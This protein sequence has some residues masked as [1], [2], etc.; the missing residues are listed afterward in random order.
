MDQ[1]GVAE[2]LIAVCC[3][4]AIVALFVVGVGAHEVARHL[5]QGAPLWFGLIFGMRGSG[6][7]KW[8]GLAICLFWLAIAVLIGLHVTGQARIVTGD[9]TP[10]EIAMTLVIGGASALGVVLALITRSGIGLI[11]GLAVFLAAAALQ[12]GAMAV[13]LQP[14]LAHDREE[15]IHVDVD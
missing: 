5:V 6:L 12:V 8:A 2:R 13:S 3:A 7:A 9:F 4:C 15:F 1:G 14:F 10:L 11:A